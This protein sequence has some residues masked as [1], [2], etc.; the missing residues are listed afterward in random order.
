MPALGADGLIERDPVSELWDGPARRLLERAYTRQ[1][2]WTETRLANPGARQLA[3]AASQG[4]NL[5]APDPVQTL[6]GSH[7]NA[8]SVWVRGFIRAVY[9]QHRWYYRQGSGLGSSRRA[10]PNRSLAIRF[11]VGR[12]M[13]VRGVVPAGRL[14]SIMALP[15]GQAALRAVQRMPDRER[16]FADDGSQAG[17]S[18]DPDTLE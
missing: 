4:I 13:P 17:A 15:G 5:L 11:Q 14:V 16:I 7:I 3:W 12:L 6:S 18:I 9:Y 1:G 2:Q 8:R 10:T